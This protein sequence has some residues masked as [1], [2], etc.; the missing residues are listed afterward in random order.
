METS[1]V[2]FNIKGNWKGD[3][4]GSGLMI[5]N[6]VKIPISA[7]AALDG[8]GIGSNPEELLAASAATCYIITLAAI[9]TKREIK[10][11]HLESSTEAVVQEEGNT[12][13]FKEIIHRPLIILID[14]NEEK[15]KLVEQLAQR[16]EKAC[17]IGKTLKPGVEISVEPEVRFA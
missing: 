16:A 11:S 5:T 9:L 1:K 6:E 3:R 7:P 4:N 8:P 12:L 2:S 13:I 15:K 17:F 14:G 10:Y